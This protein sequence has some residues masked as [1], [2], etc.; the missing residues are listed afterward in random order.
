MGEPELARGRL[1]S[2]FAYDLSLPYHGPD[3]GR[4]TTDKAGHCRA[5]IVESLAAL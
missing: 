2:G 1:N 4:S 3:N 5:R